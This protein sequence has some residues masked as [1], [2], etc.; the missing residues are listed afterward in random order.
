[1]VQVFDTLTFKIECIIDRTSNSILISQSKM[2]RNGISCN[3]WFTETDYKKRFS[4]L[5]ILGSITSLINR[6]DNLIVVKKE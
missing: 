6:F 3:Q 1:M 4:D 5:T 2:S